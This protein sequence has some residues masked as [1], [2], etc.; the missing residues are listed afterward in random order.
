MYTRCLIRIFVLLI[1]FLSYAQAATFADVKDVPRKLILQWL[2]FKDMGSLAQVNLEYADE[3]TSNG[4]FSSSKKLFETLDYID[5]VLD[6]FD[7][8][9]G[10]DKEYEEYERL[11][12]IDEYL[13]ETE[14]FPWTGS[15]FKSLVSIRSKLS[16]ILVKSF[17]ISK[18][19]TEY[20]LNVDSLFEEDGQFLRELIV[21][22]PFCPVE[23]LNEIVDYSLQGD[24]DVNV[25]LLATSNPLT[26]FQKLLKI[27]HYFLTDR[28]EGWEQRYIEHFAYLFS[29][30]N[31]DWSDYIKKWLKDKKTW[32]Q[33]SYVYFMSHLLGFSNNPKLVKIYGDQLFSLKKQIKSQEKLTLFLRNLANSAMKIK[34]F[35]LWEIVIQKMIENYRFSEFAG[36]INSQDLFLNLISEDIHG[37]HILNSGNLTDLISSLS[38][39]Q[40]SE[41][42]VR[43][44]PHI[45]NC[46]LDFEK[47]ST[48]SDFIQEFKSKCIY[49]IVKRVK[50]WTNLELKTSIIDQV[51]E[52]TGS[53]SELLN[54][55]TIDCLI[56]ML[57]ELKNEQVK[58]F[59][60]KK[61]IENAK[62]DTTRAQRLWDLAK[63]LHSD[64]SSSE[65]LWLLA[66]NPNL[67]E[68]ESRWCVK[69]VKYLEQKKDLNLP[70]CLF[71]AE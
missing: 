43:L 34:N 51:F 17:Q 20:A 50:T 59:V 27:N 68:E 19:V 35:S 23:L 69:R 71:F 57:S 58:H 70:N 26:P 60:L 13:Q 53:V 46:D 2:D 29:N 4:S 16:N 1:T 56:V 39:E 22:N 30:P 12:D 7:Q 47:Y 33:K 37:I 8:G 52:T 64:Q 41:I 66:R 15:Q 67:M 42:F 10:R 18:K 55:N 49:K 14:K 48:N 54:P 40:Q 9:I 61:I 6:E 45:Q 31:L 3:I 24:A 36:D 25:L 11:L 62:I 5:S 32:K 44:I 28:Y 21:R 65:I 63:L 38:E